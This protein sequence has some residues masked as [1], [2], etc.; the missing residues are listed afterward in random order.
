MA[1]RVEAMGD[2]LGNVEADGVV[3]PHVE[4]LRTPARR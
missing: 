2:A 4:N 3:L 1:E